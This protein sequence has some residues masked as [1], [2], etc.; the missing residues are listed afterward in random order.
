MG[1]QRAG[2][3]ANLGRSRSR[4]GGTRPDARMSR[5]GD[6]L[7]RLQRA[8]LSDRRPCPDHRRRSQYGACRVEPAQACR[9]ASLAVVGRLLSILR[10][11]RRNGEYRRLLAVSR[12]S[13]R[14]RD[15]RILGGATGIRIGPTADLDFFLQCLPLRTARP[16]HRPRTRH[17]TRLRGR[18]AQRPAGP[19][20]RRAACLFR[21]DDRA[22]VRKAVRALGDSATVLALRAGHSAGAIPGSGVRG[23]RHG[24]RAARPRRA[25]DL[26]VQLRGQLFRLASL[27]SLLWR[28][29]NRTAA[30]LSETGSLRCNSNRIEPRR[31]IE[32]LVHRIPREFVRTGRW[33]VSSSSMRRIG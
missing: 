11:G 8:L 19:N 30:A 13:S 24:D 20:N 25:A 16:F 14:P 26:R 29:G 4:H 12:S 7:G 22:F 10:P 5:R 33:I 9:H 27:R 2:L 32:P 15:A 1:I 3:S 31:G 18:P 23:R 28:T 17:C 6:R 21:N